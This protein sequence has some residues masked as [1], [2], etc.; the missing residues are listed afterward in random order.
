VILVIL[1]LVL[2]LIMTWTDSQR[3]GNSHG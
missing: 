1:I 2:H 3:N